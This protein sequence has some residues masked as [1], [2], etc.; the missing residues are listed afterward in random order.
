[1]CL[2]LPSVASAIPPAWVSN[3]P[4]ANDANPCSRT[5]PCATFNGALSQASGLGNEI[6]VLD[7]GEYGGTN[8][9]TPGPVTI[10]QTI[11]INGVGSVAGVDPGNASDAIDI[12][13]P[14]DTV[15]IENLILNGQ[16][17][18]LD[19]IKV[20]A[21]SVVRLVNV[22]ISGFTGSGV[23]FA[24]SATGSKLFVQSSSITANGGAGVLIDP[25]ATGSGT[26]ALTNDELDGNGC[27]LAASAGCGAGS[28][29]GAV[30]ITGTSL[31][32]TGNTGGGVI[33]AGS[34]TSVAV[35][36]AIITGNATGLSSA[37]GSQIVSLGANLLYGNGADGAFTSTVSTFSGPPGPAGPIGDEA[38]STGGPP[39]AA[40]SAALRGFHCDATR[41][42]AVFDCSASVSA[43]AIDMGVA[44]HAQAT[45]SRARK[46]VA[47]GTIRISGGHARLTWRARRRRL[48][49][50]SYTLTVRLSHKVIARQTVHVRGSHG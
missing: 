22:T 6:M 5:G 31:S 29:Q 43:A 33:S 30:T 2:A 50:G 46:V 19:G 21:A 26:V 14:G 4:S 1:V 40:R 20:S 25:T 48:A 45:L 10:G 41:K 32:M 47:R 24:P 42:R 18:G 49:A 28:T 11:T 16:G 39:A 7:D 8:A 37:G 38:D 44:R 9:T 3:G 34:G 15:V 36:G 17:L 23:E 35:G 27:G 13:A 12:N